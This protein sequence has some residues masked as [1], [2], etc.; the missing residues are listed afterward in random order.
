[1][2]KSLTLL[3]IFLGVAANAF[4]YREAVV[5]GRFETGRI[6]PWS[7]DKFV[8]SLRGHGHTGY[9]C[10]GY[11]EVSAY[12]TASLR[13]DLGTNI[14]PEDVKKAVLW[15]LID[16]RNWRAGDLIFN[17]GTNSHDVFLQN[18]V[19]TFVEFPLSKIGTRFAYLRIRTQHYN[20]TPD[21]VWGCVDDVSL[22][23]SPTAVR[24]TSLGRVKALYR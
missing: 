2:K 21:Y 18:G 19:W 6:A 7:T 13:Q 22:L 5:N 9:Y 11:G 4:G 17:L 8:I 14:Y 16:G 20:I 23:I 12:T 15:G 10:A 24:G 3:S 1:M